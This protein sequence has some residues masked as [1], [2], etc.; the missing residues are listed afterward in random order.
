MR[1]N[2]LTGPSENH[3][4]NIKEDQLVYAK[5][6]EKFLYAGMIFIVVSFAVYIFQIYPAG[7]PPEKSIEYLTMRAS[8]YAKFTEASVGWAWLHQLDKSDV[9]SFSSIVFIGMISFITYLRVFSLYVLKKN[10]TFAILALCQLLIFIISAL[11]LY[12]AH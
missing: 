6:L 9:I 7:L 8:E 1:K 5:T 3:H 11:G 2:K 10:T 12:A 4:Q